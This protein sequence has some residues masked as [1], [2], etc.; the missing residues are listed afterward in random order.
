MYLFT[1]LLLTIATCKAN[2]IK[3]VFLLTLPT[4]ISI[5]YPKVFIVIFWTSTIIKLRLLSYIT[6][7]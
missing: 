5:A 2:E 4:L 3:C 1:Y 6:S 7:R